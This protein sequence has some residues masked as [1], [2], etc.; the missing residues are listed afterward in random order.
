M[1]SCGASYS[2]EHDDGLLNYCSSLHEYENSEIYMATQD[3]GD[4]LEPSKVKF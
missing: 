4:Q 3:G 1:H 2:K